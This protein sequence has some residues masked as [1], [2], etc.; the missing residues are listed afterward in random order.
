MFYYFLISSSMALLFYGVIK[1]KNSRETKS[2]FAA[3]HAMSR[4]NSVCAVRE[5]SWLGI[6]NNPNEK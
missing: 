2:Y 1:K 5:A 4:K 3:N 6:E